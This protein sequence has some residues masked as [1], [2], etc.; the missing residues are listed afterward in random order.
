MILG[1]GLL[2]AGCGSD[3]TTTGSDSESDVP[4]FAD[5]QKESRPGAEENQDAAELAE[6]EE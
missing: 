2:F 1:S 4:T 5:G 6:A 3:E